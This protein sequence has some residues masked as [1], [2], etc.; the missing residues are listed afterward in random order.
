[1]PRLPALLGAIGDS[2]TQAYSVDSSHLRDHTEFSWVVGTNPTDGVFSLYERFVALGDTPTVVDAATSGRKMND[3]ARQAT[4]IVQAAAKLPAGATAYVTFELS[5]NDICDDPMTT[6]DS[7]AS[8]LDAALAILNQGLPA[9]SRI[10]ML[11]VPDYRHWR[12]MVQADP[13]TAAAYQKPVNQDRC[14]PFLGSNTRI[15]LA[16]A[17]AM[18][19]AYNAHL[20][21]ACDQIQNADG[22]D[23]KLACTYNEDLLSERDFL[24]SDLSTVDLIHPNLSGQA[25][26]AQSAWQADVWSNLVLP[27]SPGPSAAAS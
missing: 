21:D 19:D 27:P 25:K 10:L 20:R 4:A 1:M 3:A 17:G 23:G 11:S 6:P 14:P 5:A 15:S 7:F 24:A 9:G 18:L 2:Y 13:A 16:D 12:D 8:S 22:A 26:M